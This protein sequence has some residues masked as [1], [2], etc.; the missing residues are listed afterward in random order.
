MSPVINFEENESDTEVTVLSDPII[1]R[2]IKEF[3]THA[4][5]DISDLKREVKDFTIACNQK[6]EPRDAY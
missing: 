5:V 4:F 3:I 1:D 6:N 2:V